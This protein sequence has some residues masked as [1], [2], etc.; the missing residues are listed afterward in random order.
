MR[1]RNRQRMKLDAPRKFIAHV[2]RQLRKRRLDAEKLLE[3]RRPQRTQPPR[4]ELQFGPQS[5]NGDRI[6]NADS[7]SQLPKIHMIFTQTRRVRKED[8]IQNDTKYT[9]E[10]D[11]L[12]TTTGRRM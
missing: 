3:V 8:E 11:C 9:T 2:C 10:D 6:V 5:I 1:F 4:L 12:D 7:R